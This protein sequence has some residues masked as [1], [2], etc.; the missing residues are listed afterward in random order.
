LQ[1]I[2]TLRSN[3]GLTVANMSMEQGVGRGV[4]QEQCFEFADLQPRRLP[5][6]LTYFL[7]QVR[8]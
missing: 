1:R 6:R 4:G 5:L 3:S 7:M 2:G 8:M